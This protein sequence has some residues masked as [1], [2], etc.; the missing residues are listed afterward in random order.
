MAGTL[1]VP[2]GRVSQDDVDGLA[3]SE[4]ESGR[5]FEVEGHRAFRDRLAA[6]EPG[7]V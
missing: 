1:C 5:L 3:R 7:Q 4:P 2:G 6:D